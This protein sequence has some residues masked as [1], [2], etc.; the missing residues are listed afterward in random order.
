MMRRAYAKGSRERRKREARA[1]VPFGG[2]KLPMRKARAK[3]E[4][5]RSVDSCEIGSWAR[6]RP[7]RRKKL[8][9]GDVAPGGKVAQAISSRGAVT[10]PVDRYVRNRRLA[11]L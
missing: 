5:A 8:A 9:A 2:F 4:V 6:D 3:R 10:Y 11:T 7:M 1:V